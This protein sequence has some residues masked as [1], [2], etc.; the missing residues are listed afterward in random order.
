MEAAFSSTAS[1]QPLST[2]SALSAA[3]LLTTA[4]SPGVAADLQPTLVH[5]SS[6]IFL[7]P[8]VKDYQ[9]LLAGVQPGTEVHWLHSAQDAIVQITQT[10][11][12]RTG[13][14]SLHLVSHGQAGALALGS[15]GLSLSNLHSY[16]SELQSWG[17]TLS[18]DADI[19]LYGC[20]VAQ[21]TIGQSFVQ[22]LAQL[23]GADI[24]AS[25]NRTGNAA[26]GGDWTLEVNTGNIDAPLAFLPATRQGYSG[27]LDEALFAQAQQLTSGSLGT[28]SRSIVDGAG[29][30]Y[31]TGSFQGTVDFD[32]GTG[33]T[34]LTSAGNDDIFISKLDAGG[35]FLWAQSLGGS[36]GDGATGI[37]V[38]GN[39]NVYTTGTFTGTVDFDPGAGTTNLTSVSSS[40]DIFVSKLDAGGNFVWAKRLGGSSNDRATG[41]SVDGSGNVYT[42]GTFTGT[43]D[44][45]PGAGTTNLTSVSSSSDIF[46]SKLDAGGNFVWAKRLGGSS[47]KAANGISVDGN[48]NV[49]TTGTFSGTVDFD[50]GA[51]TTNLTS[52]GGNDVFVS[53]LDAGGN[54][55]W[56]KRLGGSSPNSPATIAAGISVDGSGNVYTTGYFY[57]TVDFDPGAGTT[58][59]TSVSGSTDIFISKLDTGGNFVWAK[60]LGGSN[61]DSGSGISVDENGNVYTTG[62]FRGT[63]DFDPGVSTTSLTSVSGSSDVFISKLD[64]GGNF[65]WA[66]SLGGSSPN[67]ATG[68]SVDGNGNVYTTGTFSGIADFDPGAGTFNL[69]AGNLANLFLSKLDTAGNFVQAQQLA[70]GALGTQPRSVV[71]KAGNVYTT[72]TFSGTVDFD[73]GAG[74]T[75]LISAPYSSDI[76]VSK[77]DVNG[78][79]IWVQSLSGS[80]NEQVTGISVDG[81]GNVY[82]TGTFSGTVD[83]DPGAGTTNLTSTG[84]QDLF[85]SKLDADGNFVWAKSLDGSSGNA[86]A[87]DISVDGS[88]NVYTTGYFGGTADFDPRA[89]TT[90]LISAGGTDIFISKLDADGNFVW[91]KRLGGSSNDEATGISIDGSGNVY[92]TGYFTGTADFDPGAGTTNLTSAGS[93]NIFISKLDAGGNFVWAKSLGGSSSSAA[94][95]ISVDNSDNVYTTGTFTGTTDFDPGAGTANLT[96]APGLGEIF[97]SKLDA[98]GNFVWAKSL[99]GS[100]SNRANSI[101]V[102]GSGNVYTTG[103]FYVTGDFDPGAGTTNLISAGGTDIFISKL[104]AD[105]NFVWAKRLG[106]SSNDEATGI[107][108]DG[109]GNVYT[110]GFF[111][112]TVD[113]D[114]GAGIFNLATGGSP[115]IFLSKLSQVLTP[116]ISL[117]SSTVSLNEGNSGTTAHTFTVNLS[118]T[119]AETVTVNYT[120]VDG[121]AT[122][123]DADYTAASS[124]LTFNPGET[125]K[126]ITVFVK[127]DGKVEQDETF[128]V[129]LLNPTNGKLAPNASTGTGT[130]VNDD[131]AQLLWRNSIT[132]E[133][134]VWQLNGSTLQSSYYLPTVADAN[135]Q[136]ISTA[137]F[138]RDGNADI[139]WR[140]RASGENSVWLMNSTG[141]QTSYY[142]PPVAD[143]NWRIIA[144]DD[145][146]GD[147]TA[148]LVWRHQVTGEN[149]IWQMSRTGFQTSY[150]LPPVADANWQI[151]STADFN[152]DGV[153]DLL[154]RNQATGENSI[155]RLNS[156]GLQTAYYIN[157][158]GDAN[159]Q[160]VGTADLNNDGIADLVWRNRAT[161][162]NSLWQMNS[163]G[164]Q[165]SYYIN[166]VADANW[167]VVGVAD[168]GGTSTPDLLWR[169]T[170]TGQTT[171]G[172]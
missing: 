136:M 150:Y 127:G 118:N 6:L 67:S 86:V 80:S 128:S 163:T 39:G 91:A 60:S 63:V 16:S 69:A 160:V 170:A 140:N 70:S 53:K 29:S 45:D 66:K 43:V 130:I 94:T 153:A 83:F 56:A 168:L 58:N 116:R 40:S 14:T 81:N 142:L 10:L 146:T 62:S 17:N 124:T 105:G 156:T 149:R 76:F 71:D 2:A 138:N 65:V 85:F 135:W 4:L 122:V 61:S 132:G 19:L 72:G 47:N 114:P 148:D 3:A 49:Y 125:S 12:G 52:S 164:L 109:S 73:P 152:A 120:T 59:I 55:L 64:T 143:A 100:S 155:W 9:H 171:S 166:P 112:G 54:F 144:T 25:D 50:P 93:P 141:F 26:L 115:N 36:S 126:T 13:L 95:G 96:S 167:Q 159:W 48:G 41:I 68:I 18:D 75:N 165:T 74:T 137:D 51:G 169:N 33:T 157:P 8:G 139:L 89:G 158:V 88:G 27:V 44:F 57:G 5:A 32:P 90:N 97:V 129:K 98:S 121:T 92:T 77:L 154:W 131:H 161:G 23:T 101:S 35:N 113:F 82:T 147:G 106:G 20:D 28:Q 117:S 151:V 38:D 30:V 22:Q 104:D 119:S 11:L 37:G 24:A 108:I 31:T 46:V 7:D 103:Y 34:N 107:S 145:F 42:T 78:N 172:N 134:A 99:G 111:Q 123:A 84:N 133:N 1:L 110:T 162:E 87:T 15:K 79:F 102:D 21:G